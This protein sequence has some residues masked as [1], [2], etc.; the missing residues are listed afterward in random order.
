MIKSGPIFV[1]SFQKYHNS[2]QILL[3]K[4]S[5]RQHMA[6]AFLINLI[7]SYFRKS[8]KTYQKPQFYKTAFS[9][10]AGVVSL[11]DRSHNVSI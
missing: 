11:S 3:L 7:N 8:Y 6:T 4:K 10:D 9:S 2:K 5:P 1:W